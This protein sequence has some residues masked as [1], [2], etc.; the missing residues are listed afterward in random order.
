MHSNQ[1]ITNNHE[2]QHPAWMNGFIIIFPPADAETDGEKSIMMHQYFCHTSQLDL[3]G[4]TEVE[5]TYSFKFKKAAIS[6]TTL[7]IIYVMKE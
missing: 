7:I 6:Q 3:E 4:E 5:Q 1:M 2:T